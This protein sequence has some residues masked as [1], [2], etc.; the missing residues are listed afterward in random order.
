VYNIFMS[1]KE[2]IKALPS[3][4]CGV[5]QFKDAQG[6]ILYIGKA[7]D[8]KKRMHGHTQSKDT[9]I[10][11][12]LAQAVNVDYFTCDTEEQAL[13]LEA[14]LIKEHQ[15]KYNIELKGGRSY[16]YIVITRDKHPR[17]LVLRDTN[18]AEEPAVI[19]GPYLSGVTARNAVN[20]IRKIFP[21][22]TCRRPREG[23]LYVHLKLCPCP[24]SKVSVESYGE[25][26]ENIRRILSGERK[27]L[28]DALQQ[29][30]GY[31]SQQKLYEQAQA[32]R[33]QLLAICMLY[34]G[35]RQVNE[36]LLLKEALGL[37]VSPFVIDGIDIA[38]L[39][40]QDATASAVVFRN[41]IPD[42][43]NYRHYKIKTV[44][45]MNDFAMIGEVV[46]RRYSRMKQEGVKLPDLILVDGGAGQVSAARE[47]LDKLALDIPM[48]GLAKSNEE[49]YFPGSIQ[50][51]V[52]PRE[53][54]ALHLIQ[55]IRDEAHRFCRKYHFVLREKRMTR[56]VVNKIKS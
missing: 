32:V 23:C 3:N 8:I 53:S 14:S 1:L 47:Q 56:K 30:M 52:L 5:Y 29:K 6:C 42:K 37:S 34:A 9:R 11:Q 26:I 24:G 50:P 15:P 48:I 36:L 17:V 55:R 22:C 7:I 16:T 4:T 40:G 28:V 35:K 2:A 19:F 31:L 44:K 51:M 39:A 33:D 10:Q 54:P 46:V 13:I 43:K 49:I 12:M 25:N 20:L 41:G 38:C 21:F 27:E 45:G 18:L